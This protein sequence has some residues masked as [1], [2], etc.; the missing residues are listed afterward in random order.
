MFL[1]DLFVFALASLAF[2]AI[3]GATVVCLVNEVLARGWKAMPVAIG[4]AT[5]ANLLYLIAALVGVGA[6]AAASPLVLGI[7]QWF[8]VAYLLWIAYD[9][10]RHSWH[11]DDPDVDGTR[12][13]SSRWSVFR[14]TFIVNALNAK[15]LLFF[16][17][18]LPHVA[19]HALLHGHHLPILIGSFLVLSVLIYA[20]YGLVAACFATRLMSPRIRGITQRLGALVLGVAAIAIAATALAF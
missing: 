6:L 14:R 10:W 11:L 2:F 4:G 19:S 12:M 5:L 7:L 3:P 18:I 9:T 16:V 13:D 17:V 1:H 20:A 8:G 15:N